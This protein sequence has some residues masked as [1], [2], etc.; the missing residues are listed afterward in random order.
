[1]R[2]AWWQASE[3]GETSERGEERNVHARFFSTLARFNPSPS[4]SDACHTEKNENKWL[5]LRFYQM[6]DECRHVFWGEERNS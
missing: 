3:R 2:I 1:M 6:K 5:F 4:P